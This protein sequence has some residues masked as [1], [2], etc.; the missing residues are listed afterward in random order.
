MSI[1]FSAKPL[2]FAVALIAAGSLLSACGGGSSDGPRI[3]VS[4]A[5]AYLLTSKN[6]II[7]VDLDDTEFARFVSDI[8]PVLLDEDEQIL[9]IDFRNSEGLLYALTRVGTEGRIILIDLS[10]QSILR[11][12]NLEADSSDAS[13]PYEKLSNSATYTIDFDPNSNKLR[14][15]SNSG[16][17]L[18][19]QISSAATVIA[20]PSETPK[21][22]V[23]TDANISCS[24]ANCPPTFKIAGLAYIN[25]SPTR[26]FALDTSN[27]YELDANNGNA[28]AVQSLGTT[29]ITAVS[30][31]DINPSNNKGAAVV[32]IN[33]AQ[34]VYAID[35]NGPAVYLSDLPKLPNN[36]RYTGLSFA[37]AAPTAP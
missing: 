22:L 5:N 13:D 16:T 17:N 20:N 15:L 14:V 34:S 32:T 24:I 8:I 26:I 29:G 3:Q 11:L 21:A 31:Y 33:G 30:G 27:T 36:E 4:P 9:D 18:L 23:T 2:A 37:T 35:T 28:T 10:S 12:G 19:V 1:R 7:G 25:E 6:R